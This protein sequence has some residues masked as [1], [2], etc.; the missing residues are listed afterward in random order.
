[1]RAAQFTVSP[2]SCGDI[3]AACEIFVVIDEAGAEQQARITYLK[4]GTIPTK[5]A[6]G[7]WTTVQAEP[8][9]RKIRMHSIRE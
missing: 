8:K 1:M 4:A 9:L 3:E 2:K 7:Y 6:C 5:H